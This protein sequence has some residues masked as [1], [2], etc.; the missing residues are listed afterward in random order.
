MIRTDQEQA[1]QMDI[2]S[3][4]MSYRIKFASLPQNQFYSR[5]VTLICSLGLGY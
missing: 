2:G 5:H 3:L 1:I 4:E